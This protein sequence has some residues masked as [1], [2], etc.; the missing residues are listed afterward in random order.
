[1]RR[2]TQV[3][4]QNTEQASSARLR[5]PAV[6][7][8]ARA[9]ARCGR[10]GATPTPT[11]GSVWPTI[12]PGRGEG[13]T[14]LRRTSAPIGFSVLETRLFGVPRLGA[15]L[16]ASCACST[17]LGMACKSSGSLSR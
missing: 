10:E 4:A 7:N 17:A 16:Y 9:A 11:I 6:R 2:S 13:L 3:Y 12:S 14:S 5:M 15:R 1:M 8:R